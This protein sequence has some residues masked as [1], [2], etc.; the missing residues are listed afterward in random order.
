[1]QFFLLF[2]SKRYTIPWRPSPHRRKRPA[3]SSC[4]CT[5]LQSRG[6]V[7]QWCS[8]LFFPKPALLCPLPLRLL[9]LGGGGSASSSLVVCGLGP[10]RNFY[11]IFVQKYLLKSD[12]YYTFMKVYIPKINLSIW[13]SHFESQKLVMI[14]IPKP[15]PNLIQNGFLY[16]PEGVQNT[17]ILV[18]Y[19]GNIFFILF[20]DK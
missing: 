18:C 2:I 14:Y 20:S 10:K 9:L 6:P 11:Y 12:I 19:H 7:P 13:F 5:G 3:R 17:F 1:M 16:Q 8:R 4:T 15:D